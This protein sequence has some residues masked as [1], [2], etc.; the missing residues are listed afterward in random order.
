MTFAEASIDR[1][2]RWRFE[3]CRI[4]LGQAAFLAGLVW[5]STH[6][7]LIP[8]WL[9][10]T[11]LVAS[12]E[13]ELFRN[14]HK[15]LDAVALRRAA[16][17]S[18]F[19]TCSVFSAIG[20]ILLLHASPLTLAEATLLTCAVCLNNAVMTRGWPPAT[21]A[22]VG[23]SCVIMLLS[24]PLAAIMLHFRFSITDGLVMELGSIAYAIFIGL[25]VRTLNRQGRARHDALSDLERR[26]RDVAQAKEEAETARARWHILFYQSPLPQVCFDASGLHGLLAPHMAAGV[27]RP[28]DVLLKS[29]RDV[30]EAVSVLKL[31]EANRAMEELYGVDAFNGEIKGRYFDTSFLMGFCESLNAIDGDGSF[32]PFEARILREDGKSVDVCVHIRTIPGDLKPWGL[33]IAT[34]VDMTNVRLAAKAQEDALLAAETANRAKS[35]F[36]ATMS[37]EIR[38]PLNGV[39]GMVQAMERD[40]LPEHQRERVNLIGESGETLLTILNDILDLSK[41]EAGKLELEEVEFDLGLLA[42]GAQRTFVHMADAKGLSFDLQVEGAAQGTYRGDATRVRQVFYNLISNAVKFTAVG[43]VAVHIG[44]VQTGVRFTVTDTGIGMSSAQI[45]RLFDKFVQGDSSTTRIFGGTGLGLAICRELCRAMG[46]EIVATSEIG[47]GSR[48]TVDLPL[49]RIGASIRIGAADERPIP[50]AF[51]QGLLRVLAAEDN[52]V[53]QIVLK[54]ILNQAGLDLTLVGNGAEAVAA[55]ESGEWDLILMDI[56]MPEVDGITATRLIRQKEAETGRLGTPIIALTANAMD[57]QVAAYRAA[58]MNAFVGKPI[59]IAA[60]FEAIDGVTRK[61]GVIEGSATAA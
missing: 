16:L 27:E 2:I 26:S 47:R 8:I 36:L 35:D 15:R 1:V 28:G 25:L 7:I 42:M 5:T 23:A 61:S 24:T 55:W 48:F 54:T 30:K 51:D 10:V 3:D 46:G 53:N 14:L 34:F 45:E 56:Q 59:D 44:Q 17:V 41:I 6:S 11:F 37:H 19:F 20:P 39:L 22:A 38:T 60:L 57:H 9:V 52:R 13:A 21:L 40:E 49:V 29:V 4:R 58:G 12:L 50:P 33:C 31:T 18:M 32:P 43:S